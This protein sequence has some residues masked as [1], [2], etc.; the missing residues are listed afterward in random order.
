MLNKIKSIRT[1]RSF[2]AS[3]KINKTILRYIINGARFS[4]CSRNSQNIRYK[5]INDDKVL[6]KVFYNVKFAAAIDWSPKSPESPRAYILLCTEKNLNYNENLLYF[7][8]GISANNIMLMADSLGLGGCIIGAYNKKEIENIISLDKKY[9]SHILIALGKP[10]D[11]IKIIPPS[12][13]NINYSRIDD[14]H[15]VPKLSLDELII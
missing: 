15:F 8:M 10:K 2:D 3:Y 5:L 1:H 13:G 6:D 9:V 11:K 7:D 12:L 14:K 4:M